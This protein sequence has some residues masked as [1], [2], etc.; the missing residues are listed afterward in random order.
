M[1]GRIAAALCATTCAIAVVGATP[2]SAQVR[3]SLP[4]REQVEGP[5]P[6][7]EA[8]NSA[9]RVN[10][11][12]AVAAPCAFTDSTIEVAIDRV[13]FVGPD[14]AALA[15]EL[16]DALAAIKPAGGKQKL[17]Y[18][19][20]LRDA[21]A[22]ELGARGYVAAVSIPPQEIN[23]GEAQFTVIAPRFGD[24][25]VEG[26][27]GRAESLL[28]ARLNRLKA[29][30]VLNTREIERMLLLANDIPGLEVV[31]SI[32]AGAM[33]GTV[34][35]DVRV[36]HAPYQV[37]ASI[38]NFGPR[39]L[40]RESGTVRADYFGL[41]GQGDR[42]FIGGSTTFDINRQQTIQAGHSIQTLGG[43]TIGVRGTYVWSRPQ[44]GAL[45]L[46]ARSY[47]IGIEAS[48]PI[49]RSVD[50]RVDLSAGFDVIGQSVDLN[51]LGFRFALTRDDLRVFYL[52]GAAQF[53][54]AQAEGWDRYGVTINAEIRQGIDFGGATPVNFLRADGASAS[55]FDGSASRTV[56]R[57]GTE[58]FFAFNRWFQI[59][60][61]LQGQWSSGALLSYEEYFVGNLTLGRGYDPGVTGGDVAIGGR[62]EPRFTF[63]V[64][65]RTT[66]Q[67][68]GFYEAVRIWNYDLGTAEDHR[69]LR[70]WGFGARATISG[71]L[72][73]QAL[74]AR[75]E[76]PELLLPGA[77][78]AGQRF[79]FQI[80]YQF[81]PR[82]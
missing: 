10:D 41:F 79:L 78:R 42:T 23:A 39:A 22:A 15:P 24:I 53:R 72:S 7:T 73:L 43:S 81:N 32:R 2:A 71:A 56:V 40:G 14:G 63:E 20:T 34:D 80:T 52:R 27:A 75:P 54:G 29:M 19:C 38:D 67:L 28:R 66:A 51:A 74:Y 62:V 45:D 76:N 55:R 31:M 64:A 58:G 44:L 11:E 6:A 33:P 61:S 25:R 59:A 9:V 49:V 46:D 77:P 26:S 60:G 82:R 48:T 30:P 37:T 35:G 1:G 12:R 36:R 21:A 65:P 5:K 13:R 3:G 50:T 68:F 69:S 57:G 47:V 17:A 70:S 8:P 4:S 18:L 16:I